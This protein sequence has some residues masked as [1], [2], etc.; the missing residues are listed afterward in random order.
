VVA[1]E[2]LLGRAAGEGVVGSDGCLTA[3]LARHAAL[4]HEG[5]RGGDVGASGDGGQVVGAPRAGQD[6]VL[7]H[8]LEGAQAVS[9]SPDAASGQ[10]DPHRARLAGGGARLAVRDRGRLSFGPVLG[11]RHQALLEHPEA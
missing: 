7:L 9:R 8:G 10:A 2:L 5:H 11:F 3:R 1:H 4:G 6:P